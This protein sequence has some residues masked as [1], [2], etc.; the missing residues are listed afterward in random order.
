MKRPTGILLLTLAMLAACSNAYS[1]VILEQSLEV[2]GCGGF[3]YGTRGSDEC[4]SEVLRWSFDANSSTLALR[5][6][7]VVLNCC[8]E[9]SVE[10][11]VQDG[12]TIVMTETDAPATS[13]F[14][15]CRCICTFDFGATVKLGDPVL[16]ETAVKVMRLVTDIKEG[17]HEEEVFT[18][19]I[20][21]DSGAGSYCIR[22]GLWD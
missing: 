22:S 6:E 2:S 3:A 14:R 15:R 17:G 9:R 7:N 4:D 21:L 13:G 1:P 12:N 10:V 5:N 20:D 19:T 18:T 16:G 8:G 11:D